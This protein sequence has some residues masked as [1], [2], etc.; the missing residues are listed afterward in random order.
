MDA[1]RGAIENTVSISQFNKGLAGRI[2]EEVK[3]CGAKVVM[4]NNSAECVLMS[5]EEY[6]RLMDEVNDARLLAEASARMSHYDP[7]KLLTDQQIDEALGLSPGDYTDI[8][9]V[10][11]E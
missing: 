7:D 11:F 2:F 10:E 9:E 3:R 4:K 6:V 1:I 8:S 5:P